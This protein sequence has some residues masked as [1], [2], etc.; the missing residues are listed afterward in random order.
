MPTAKYL[1][2]LLFVLSLTNSL[3]G[4][5]T[6]T[7]VFKGKYYPK[8]TPVLQRDVDHLLKN[9]KKKLIHGKVLGLIV[10]HGKYEAS[11]QTAAYAYR[12]LKGRK[13]DT[14][15][16]IGPSHNLKF[17]GLSIYAKDFY[18]T[19]LGKVPINVKLAKDLILENDF[20]T[21]FPDAHLKE[22]SIEIQIPFLQRTLQNFQILPILIGNNDQDYYQLLTEALLKHIIDQNI[23]IIGSGNLSH[24]R[25]Y[26][27]AA[28]MD[29]K[30]IAYLEEF[31]IE[32]MASKFKEGEC[33]T[34][35][36]NSILTTMLTC[37]KLGADRVKLLKYTNS[38]EITGIQWQTVG[39]ASLALFDI[40]ELS[41]DT[42]QWLLRHSRR[43]LEEYVKFKKFPSIEEKDP[44]LTHERGV[45]ITIKKDT[46]I[47]GY[48]GYVLPTKPLYRAVAD[49]TI[50]AAT[51]D[52]KYPPLTK[53]ELSLVKI[54]ISVL[55]NIEKVKD[56]NLIEIGVHGIYLNKNW[57]SAIILPHIAKE[58]KWSQEEFLEKACQRAGL[59]SH[60]WKDDD[61]NI[62]LFTSQTFSE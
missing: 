54:E 53:E 18:A 45:Y 42:K 36:S 15:I 19:P 12:L 2:P 20:I 37:Q 39:Y 5:D 1:L 8:S 13:I 38:G 57:Q 62:Y 34:C 10:P 47:R 25:S 21:F 16:I 24:F 46:T 55:S 32:K 11:G 3:L 56:F 43:S 48:L 61:I 26:F 58:N 51:K 6:R 17:P 14:I 33:E 52:L 23:L 22:H 49:G 31:D 44:L 50:K 30:T 41:E 7:P 40:E 4:E 28:L 9:S 27:D 59:N 29:R 35:A 60:A